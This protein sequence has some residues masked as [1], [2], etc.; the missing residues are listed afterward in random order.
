MTEIARSRATLQTPP[1]ADE[2]KAILWAAYEKACHA[3]GVPVPDAHVTHVAPI[4]PTLYEDVNLR[5]PHGVLWHMQP[6]SEQ[7]AE[8]VRDGVE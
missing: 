2:C 3:A 4:I 5:C 8:W 6:T 7:I 1:C